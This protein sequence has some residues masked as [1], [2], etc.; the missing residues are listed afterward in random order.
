MRFHVE[1]QLE[2]LLQESLSS[3]LCQWLQPT[4]R[5]KADS[6]PTE[7]DCEIS[8]VPDLTINSSPFSKNTSKN[9]L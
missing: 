2:E 1:M 8:Y 7:D 6:S 9:V 5:L 4:Q 3:Y